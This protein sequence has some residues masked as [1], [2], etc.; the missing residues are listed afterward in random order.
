LKK[1]K[2]ILNIIISN[3]V[4]SP[5]K[6]EQNQNKLYLLQFWNLIFSV[7]LDVRFASVRNIVFSAK[8]K[9]VVVARNSRAVRRS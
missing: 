3:D 2:F 9:D 7:G 8:N 5:V 6:T 4:V 1:L